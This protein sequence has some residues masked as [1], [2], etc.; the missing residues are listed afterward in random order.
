MKI[1]TLEQR[2]KSRSK[3][4]RKKLKVLEFQELCFEVDFEVDGTVESADK[5]LD[6]FLTFI[7]ELGLQTAGSTFHQNEI[8]KSS[9][10][11]CCYKTKLN[12]HIREIIIHYLNNNFAVTQSSNLKDAWHDY[13]LEA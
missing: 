9:F 11:I 8:T 13:L 1:L 10:C 4:L 2:N 5:K 12:E 3:R 6:D 7:E